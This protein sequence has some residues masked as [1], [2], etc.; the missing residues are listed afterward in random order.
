MARDIWDLISKIFELIVF[1]AAGYYLLVAKDYAHAA[2][3]FALIAAVNSW[4]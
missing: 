1:F 2:A 4:E 3:L